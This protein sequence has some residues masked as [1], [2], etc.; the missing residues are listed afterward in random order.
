MQSLGTQC[1]NAQRELGWHRWGVINFQ[2]G[3]TTASWYAEANDPVE[4]KQMV[5]QRR[6]GELPEPQF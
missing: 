6:G 3:E 2:R 4:K 5:I 1:H